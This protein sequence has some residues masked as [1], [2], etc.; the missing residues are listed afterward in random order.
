VLTLRV[1]GRRPGGALSPAEDVRTDDE[2][3]V[4]VEC[5]S[6]TDD[7]FPPTRRAVS[8]LDGARGVRVTRERVQDEDRVRGVVIESPP[9]FVRDGHLVE[10]VSSLED[11]ALATLSLQSDEST[12]SRV[13]TR[14]PE[15]GR[16]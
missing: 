3:L 4:R 5:A 6:R 7:A 15:P 9:G 2:K 1:K 11:E 13:V 10:S 8:G 12:I 14:A 16:P